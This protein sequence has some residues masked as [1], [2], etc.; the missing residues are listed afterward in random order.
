MNLYLPANEQDID[1]L[2]D[3]SDEEI[4]QAYFKCE[5]SIDYQIEDLGVNL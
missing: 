5:C 1:D 3:L 2:I 4:E